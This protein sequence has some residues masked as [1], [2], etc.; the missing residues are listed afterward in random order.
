MNTTRRH[1]LGLVGT[2]MAMSLVGAPAY[3]EP[4]QQLID[5]AKKEGQVV[6]YTGLIV[7]Q[8][9]RPLAEAFQKKY[10]IEVKY[11]TT[12]DSDTVLKL[13]SQARAGK[14]EADIFDTPGT[15]IAPLAAA[16]LIEPFVPDSIAGYDPMF[17]PASKLYSG[18]YTLFLTT[19]YNTDLV[20]ADEAPKTYEDLLD[21][22]WKGK[23]VWTDTRG[24]SGP[25][26]F[27]GNILHS[28]GEEKG[29]DYLRKLSQQQIARDPGSQRV[30]IDK[31]ISGQFQI[32]LMTYNHHAEISKAKGA[33]IGWVKMEPL[34]ANLG[35]ISLVKNAPHPNAGKLFLDTL[36]SEEGANII[37]EANYPPGHP[38]V[39]AKIPA[40]SP[41]TGNFKFYLLPP[42]V[43]SQQ[44][45]PLKT[46]LKIY[47]ELFK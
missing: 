37:R 32:G 25:A 43:A 18:I 17:K 22:K 23:M 34:V 30:V 40:I 33:P 41:K 27:I 42:E 29:M 47:D 26:G 7:P 4:S 3:A 45:E 31:V 11:A 44:A 13:T 20:S 21:P 9:V 8:V 24:V 5:A 12:G 10:G 2:A 6:W 15:A 16:N 35:A 46:W 14:M 1:L 19:T 39:Q 38:N 36:F 28:M